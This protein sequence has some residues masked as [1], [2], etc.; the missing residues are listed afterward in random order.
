MAKRKKHPL[1]MPTLIK[2]DRNT[3]FS[4]I[5]VCHVPTGYY[6]SMDKQKLDRKYSPTY[7]PLQDELVWIIRRTNLHI[8]K[9][10]FYH[11]VRFVTFHKSNMLKINWSKIPLDYML[12]K[13]SSQTSPV[14]VWTSSIHVL[15]LLHAAYF[16]FT[17]MTSCVHLKK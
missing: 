14:V 3:K 16:C 5:F 13:V 7:H 8:W 15:F 10:Q 6:L 11:R 4:L 12:G 2:R 17:W 9:G 1:G